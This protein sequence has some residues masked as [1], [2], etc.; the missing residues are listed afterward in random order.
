MADASLELV[1]N[2]KNN[3]E[4]AF[5][6]L[7]DN[8]KKVAVAVGAAALSFGAFGVKAVKDLGNLGEELSN[9]SKRTSISVE[10]LSIL[11]AASDGAGIPLESLTGTVK[12]MQLNLADWED[13]LSKSSGL[14]DM[15]GL[16]FDDLRTAS[17]EQQLFAIGN[18]L[19]K[20]EDPIKRNTIAVGLL[21]KSGDELMPLFDATKTGKESM[22]DM[23]R[24][25]ERTGQV[26][27]ESL[28]AKALKADEAFDLFDAT[29]KGITLEVGSAFA[30]MIANLAEWFD[31]NHEAVSTFIQTGLQVLGETFTWIHQNVWP[32][33]EEMLTK[34]WEWWG[35]NK[36]TVLTFV[37]LGLNVL[38]EAL[39]FLATNLDTV[40]LAL[41]I[42]I[43]QSALGGIIKVAQQAMGAGG[44]GGVSTAIGAMGKMI[45]N[46]FTLSIAIAWA[47][48]TVWKLIEAVKELKGLIADA[49]TAAA[50][51]E[52]S[53]TKMF[54]EGKIS[55]DQFS[56]GMAGV[57][58]GKAMNES[59][60]KEKAWLD[61]KGPIGWV[62]KA[63]GLGPKFAEGG[64]VPQYLASGGFG[65]GTD[66]VP[67]M[68]TPGELILNKAQ[69]KNLAGGMGITINLQGA[70]FYGDDK[71]FAE[72][73]GNT[74][75][76]SL[77]SH[78][79]FAT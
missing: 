61:N 53:I 40:I 65:R 58:K 70:N 68:L 2:G 62:Q 56:S 28:L 8:L 20:I 21:G 11:K 60:K 7:G 5:K 27:D 32:P 29:M 45:A 16:S 12:K 17:P 66:T 22:D 18:E 51:A 69:Q 42:F 13:P 30:P 9:L 75:T 4:A 14:M 50:N 6:G 55:A 49:D 39:Q 25:A 78:V 38:K 44:V 59:A 46:P 54:K 48:E 52:A 77:K 71:K 3:T 23:R 67:A 63:V 73:I 24:A 36:D 15:L 64:I 47:G 37:N 57:A 72:K 33:I 19:A 34:L 74:L 41:G 31:K 79:K 35:K 26:M 76:K 43:G 10:S 1:I